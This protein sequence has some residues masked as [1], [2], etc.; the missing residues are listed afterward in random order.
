M[1]ESKRSQQSHAGCGDYQDMISDKAVFVQITNL[2]T[3]NNVSLHG[4]RAQLNLF[5][6][7]KE[8]KL[9]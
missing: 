1:S 5:N 8:F 3:L 6:Y 4:F 9:F 2:T 7:F